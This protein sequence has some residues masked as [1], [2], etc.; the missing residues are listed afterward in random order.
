MNFLIGILIGVFISTTIS[1]VCFGVGL[2]MFF[3]TKWL[4]FYTQGL[5]YSLLAS[6][7]SF[8]CI[9]FIKA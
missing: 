9:V 5:L 4:N 2:V 7:I 8:M 3:N 6:F 1:S